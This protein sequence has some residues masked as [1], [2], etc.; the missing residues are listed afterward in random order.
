MSEKEPVTL[1]E[2]LALLEEALNAEAGSLSPDMLLANVEGWDSMG[3]LLVMAEFDEQLGLTLTEDILS[4]I[5]SIQD[6]VNVVHSAGL[7]KS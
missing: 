1:V 4:Q 5:K 3:V 2:L 6:I 7:L